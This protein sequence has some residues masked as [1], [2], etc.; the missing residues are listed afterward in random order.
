MRTSRQL[1]VLAA[2]TAMAALA[3]LSVRCD[4]KPAGTSAPGSQASQQGQAATAQPGLAESQPAPG[5]PELP[6]AEAVLVPAIGA[7]AEA[8]TTQAAEVETTLPPQVKDQA[9]QAHQASAALA[10]AEVKSLQEAGQYEQ[11]KVLAASAA[12]DY[13]DTPAAAELPTLLK[14][15]QDA[16]GAAARLIA[17]AGSATDQAKADRHARF[18]QAR[19]A[20]LAS[21]DAQEYPAAVAS[22]RKALAEEDDA[23]TRT[24]LQQA[25][26]LAGK[27]RL[28]VA[29]FDVV[30]EVGIPDVGRIVPELM[31]GRFDPQR[32]QLVER[33][34]LAAAMGEQGLTVAQ[35]V[36]NPTVLRL[37]RVPAVRYLVVGTV[38][39]LGTLAVSA[40]LVDAS[41]GEVIQTADAAATDAMG[42][43]N[44]LGELAAVL[45]MSNEEKANYLAFRQRQIDAMAGEDAA[46][47]AA[48][49]AQRLADLQAERDRIARQ[50]AEAF[51]RWQ[52]QR[53]AGVAVADA[54][55]MLARGDYAAAQR[56]AR[57]AK[58]RFAD[59]SLA[60]ELAGLETLAQQRLVAQVQQ[61]RDA[62]AWARLQ[63]EQA[64]RHQRFGRLRD[65]GWAAMTAGD[66]LAA[67]AAYQNALNEEDNPDVRAM[68]DQLVRRTQRPGIA[69]LEFDVRGDVGL[70]GHGQGHWLAAW[71]LREFARDGGPYRIVEREELSACLARAG[72]ENADVRRDPTQPRMRPLRDTIRYLVLGTAK[73]GSIHLSAT[74][75]DLHTGRVVQTAAV[76]AENARVLERALGI[77]ASVL[78]M[79]DAEKGVYL[80]RQA[81]AGWMAR[82]DAS[83]AASRWDDALDAYRR[84]CRI[85]ETK[86]ARERLA[87]AARKVEDLTASRR[88]YDAAMAAA[89]AAARAGDW[90]KAMDLYRRALSILPT[91]QA[92]AGFEIAR[93]KLLDGAQD[94]KRL[95]DKCLAEAE[96]FARAADWPRALEA[97]QHA[98]EFQ[99]S[100]QAKA[101]AEHAR[102]QIADQQ[103]ARRK[104]YADEMAQ[105]KAAIQAGD[106]DKALAAFTRAAAIDNTREAAA[107]IASA[108]KRLADMQAAAGAYDAAFADAKA[109]AAAGGWQKALDA[110]TRAAA[111]RNTPDAQAGI[112][113]A[114]KQLADAQQQG[115][116]RKPYDA[117]MA[118][119]AAHTRDGNWQEALD[120][121][122]TAYGHQKTPQALAGITTATKM[123]NDAQ[124]TR[125]QYDAALAA[126]AAAAKAGDW[127]RA[128]TA[129]QQAVTIDATPQAKAGA[130]MARQKLADA[131]AGDKKAQY[132]RLMK[133]GDAAAQA[134]D[135]Q[136]ALAL[137]TQ[138][139]AID[140][141]PE[142]QADIAAARKKLADAAAAASA[143]AGAKQ[144]YGKLIVEANAAAKTAD[145][146]KALDAYTKAAAIDNTPQIQAAIANA[147]K[148][149][150][151]AAAAAS[152]A[153]AAEAKREYT[154]LMADATAAF[155][156]GDWQKSLDT[157][158]KAAAIDNTPQA[159]AGIAAAKKKLADAATD[160]EK[161]KLYGQA[162]AAAKAAADAND[163]QK[164]LDAYT[165]AYDLKKTNEAKAGMAAA[166]KKLK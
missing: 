142:A 153:P 123:L 87:V 26:D 49:E 97:Y 107:G 5:A 110:Y 131:A 17:E 121:Y 28:A 120:A 101:G 71:L 119:A 130:D 79:N 14:Q 12:K 152:A 143:T 33:A 133:Q 156:A 112:A 109:A 62:E 48:A 135:W 42:L 114:R 73:H 155:R 7:E 24:L 43:Q 111:A 13:A 138:A 52:H 6:M 166:K 164:A 86:E 23:D 37:K 136:K 15:V 160:Q 55:A 45:Q 115:D 134:G 122:R 148:K 56:L 158:T 108:H 91:P 30:G 31:L 27:P 150:T 90:D 29:E 21:M 83:A 11:A 92:K 69:V 54:K 144:E 140:N 38:S 47:R 163:W 35:I 118:D 61:Q 32:F 105:A 10:V 25:S 139:A 85:Q 129:Y 141:T 50:Q 74:M 147:K 103:Q 116:A 89:V 117:A 98:S 20:A 63:A 44:S 106:W 94:R 81:F 159:Q 58:R 75:F 149:L 145:W 77:M 146:Q 66:L 57:W 46:A 60:A 151:D 80:D 16:A 1:G 95:H 34:R 67:M 36:Q 126:G 41:S 78:R 104:A 93:K 82:G 40:R 125:K 2:V 70:P 162:M 88:D 51:G 128:L 96:A 127:Q 132:A 102:R 53:D 22:F 99:P 157:Y 65:Q 72:L 68:L 39:R 165:K 161:D 59:T 124:Y 9:Q 113:L 3:L 137:L 84:A 64:A 18:V 100:D 8:P 4:E 76:T 154:K 19:D